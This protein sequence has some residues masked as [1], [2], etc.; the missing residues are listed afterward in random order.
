MK[1]PLLALV[2]LVCAGSAAAAESPANVPTMYLQAWLG[3]LGTSSDSWKATDTN[4][5][6]VLGDLGTLPFGGGAGQKLWGTGSWKIGF[7][8]GALGTWKSDNTQFRGVSSGGTTVQVKV[9]SKF[10]SLGVFMGAVASVNLSQHVRLYVAGGPSATWA[11]V[12]DDGNNNDTTGNTVDLSN[13]DSDASFV[14]YGRAGIEF[15]LANGFTFG[16]SVRY[17][18]DD[19]SFG[20]AGDLKLDEPLYLV[21]LGAIL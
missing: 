5:D 12:D 20:S 17:A 8:G 16:A 10:F 4:S 18:D 1:A 14:A 11:W 15:A 21:T 19:F 9:D 6:S 3:G 7:E 13:S 2:A